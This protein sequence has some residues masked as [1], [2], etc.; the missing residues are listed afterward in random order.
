L[1]MG[2]YVIRRI[3]EMIPVVLI[4]IVFNFTIVHLA[5]GDPAVILAGERAT[6]E[7]VEATRKRY[8]LD[9]PIH[10]QLI[11]YL[12]SLMR[13][14]FGDSLAYHRPVLE[15]IVEKIPATL[16]LVLTSQLV[17]MVLGTLIGALSAKKYGSRTDRLISFT[18]VILYSMPVF[19]FGLILILVFGITLRWFPIWGITSPEMQLS[20][21]GQVVDIL[22]HLFL[23][24][25][26]LSAAY[27][28]PIFV[29]LSRSSVMEV[30]K[31]DFIMA[32]RA[33]GLT[34]N[35][36]FFK[37]AL[38]NALLPTVTQAG[39]LLGFVLSGALMTETVFGWP[40]L[41]RFMYESIFRR[42]YPT[43]M[44]LFIITSVCVAVASLIT[45]IVYALL[46]PRVVYK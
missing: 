44:G 24:V 8:G 31:E 37:H 3:L 36:V 33:K 22:W 34:E 43:L 14:D 2:E 38:R 42:D 30:M 23:P 15:L 9:R 21:W 5:P 16:L 35:V 39:L 32:A 18:S 1:R 4:V 19:W 20:G 11:L 45:D 29:R 13:G 7:Y 12:M 25:V 6:A 10:E 26:T 17:S 28:T 27:L 46:D 40:G 41:G